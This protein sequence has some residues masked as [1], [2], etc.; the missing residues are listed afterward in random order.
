MTPF[1][2]YDPSSRLLGV[3]AAG[4]GHACML[5]HLIFFFFFA[6]LLFLILFQI[7]MVYYNTKY[8][9]YNASLNYP[10]G[11]TVVAVFIKV[12]K[13]SDKRSIL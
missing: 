3:G 10:D 13:S 4:E 5:G 11:R 1:I 12:G 7:H 8:G 6:F 2:F 9:S